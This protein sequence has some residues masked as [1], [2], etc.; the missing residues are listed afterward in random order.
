MTNFDDLNDTKSFIKQAM[1]IPLLE[2][3]DEKSLAKKWL[4]KR[5]ERA[6]HKLTQSH[7]RLVI[8]FAMKYKNYG[9]NISDLIQEGNIG[10]MKAAERFEISKDVRFSTYAGW[11]IRAAIQDFVLKNWSLVRIASTSKQKSLFFNLRKLKQKI[12]ST[13]NGT[14]DY[15]TAH[16]L[17]Q[18]LDISTSDVIK[19][20]NRLSQN[21]SSLNHKISDDGEC[22]VD[23]HSGYIIKTIDAST[24]EGY[25][26]SGFKKISREIIEESVGD[27][28]LEQ[29]K[30]IADPTT[31]IIYIVINAL[32]KFMGINLEH[33]VEYI[34]HHVLDI[35]RKAIPNRKIY[36]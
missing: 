35:N 20:D 10:L 8:A 6:L 9:L 14:I 5:D 34:T 31:E 2:E 26:T 21:D 32:T 4:T 25:E 17:A 16:G 19:M 27:I 30:K 33:K 23:K 7:I 15:Q 11:W 28:V 12:K 29:S 36:E 24:D 13:E 22:W 3:Q 18:S 1:S